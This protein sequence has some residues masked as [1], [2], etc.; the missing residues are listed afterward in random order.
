MH[1]SLTYVCKFIKILVYS[2]SIGGACT[3]SRDSS[4]FI[5]MCVYVYVGG[6]V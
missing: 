2:H 4:G 6:I 1:P 5:A 3:I